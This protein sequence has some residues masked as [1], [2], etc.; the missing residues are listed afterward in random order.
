MSLLGK[1]IHELYKTTKPAEYMDILRERNL[2]LEA[3]LALWR[4]E[5]LA[6]REYLDLCSSYK[7]YNSDRYIAWDATRKS[8]L[9]AGLK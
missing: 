8:T 9:E 5:A 2:E 7:Y 3:E 6:A 4:A 1:G